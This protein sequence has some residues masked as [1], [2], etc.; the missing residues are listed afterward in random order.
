MRL[1]EC[2]R[3]GAQDRTDGRTL[4]YPDGWETLGKAIL[5]PAC[6][7]RALEKPEVSETIEGY[8]LSARIGDTGS[9]DWI[10]I[11]A[12]GSQREIALRDIVAV[13]VVAQEERA[14]EKP[15]LT[16]VNADD[17]LLGGA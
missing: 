8:V 9:I 4:L 12:H 11:V 16:V 6:V 17:T 3:C 1:T 5:C 14:L 2:R 13:T 10:T 15:V 7:E